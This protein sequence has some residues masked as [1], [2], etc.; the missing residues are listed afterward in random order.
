VPRS[1]A[2]SMARAPSDTK[3]DASVSPTGYSSGPASYL[4]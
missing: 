2:S 1:S 3:T 4:R